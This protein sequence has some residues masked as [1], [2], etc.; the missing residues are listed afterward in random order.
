MSTSGWICFDA[1]ERIPSFRSPNVVADPPSHGRSHAPL[2]RSLQRP[3]ASYMPPSISLYALHT[4][5]STCGC[6]F[7]GLRCDRVELGHLSVPWVL[8]GEFL[9]LSHFISHSS[10][11]E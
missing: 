10:M 9:P 3:Y 4:P 11:R 8:T 2:S 1:W 5:S 7:T 6:I